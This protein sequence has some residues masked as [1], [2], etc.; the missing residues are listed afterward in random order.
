MKKTRASA[1]RPTADTLKP[2]PKFGTPYPIGSI[3]S[4]D[5]SRRMKY[6]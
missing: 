2:A 3:S 4:S 5:S 6:E 1:D